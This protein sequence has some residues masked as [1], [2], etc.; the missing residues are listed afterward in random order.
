MQMALRRIISTA[1]PAAVTV[2]IVT[3]WA[4]EPSI[5]QVPVDRQRSQTGLNQNLTSPQVASS[6][7]DRDGA[8]QAEDELWKG[9][10]LSRKG[11]F[12]EAIPHLLEARGRVSNEYAASFNLA[13]CYVGIREFKQA[14]QVMDDL[15]R[16]GHDGAEIENLR[17]QAYIGQ[18]QP[19]EGFASLQKAAA[20]TPQNEKLYLFV[21]DASMDQQD[22]ALG[23]KIVDIGLLNL[24]LSPSLHYERGMLLSQLD[25]FD[26]AKEDFQLARK[27]A[28]GSEIG[29]LSAA[30]E[31]LLAG[32]LPEAI[33]AARESISKGFQN[34]ILLTILGEAL[35]RSGVNPDQPE[36]VDAQTA[37]QK[38]VAERP[39][40]P[41]S[42]IAL[43]KLCL[44]AGRLDEAIAHLEKARQLKPGQPSVYANLAKAYQR[45]GD[46]Q[47]AEDAL[48][49]LAQLN[50]EQAERIRSA[51]GDRKMS[52]G[53]TAAGVEPNEIPK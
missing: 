16:S 4:C 9:T 26:R 2:V 48:A 51:P 36:F 33:R 24:P 22:Y 46:S 27:L 37:L 42:Q 12:S 18:G 5:A 45:H 47:A 13:L 49:A 7:Q 35:L 11:L 38:S 25:E 15:R 32:N 40:D 6:E 10:A 31:E 53:G 28:P 17:A 41:S 21:A 1:F 43:G 34:P 20:L 52:Y 3:S 14:I 44:A 30:Q 50:Q 39:N 8:F 23:L 19:K 29:Y